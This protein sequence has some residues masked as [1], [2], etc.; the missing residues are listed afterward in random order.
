M[1]ARWLAMHPLDKANHKT[2]VKNMNNQEGRRLLPLLLLLPL[3]ITAPARAAEAQAALANGLR[4]AD[5]DLPK[6]E[7][8]DLGDGWCDWTV[9][10]ALAR[11]A[12]G[13]V[14]NRGQRAE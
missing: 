10:H 12:A 7:N 1:A 2:K 11:E 3:P 6:A 8:G 13:A 5:R 14:S 4:V 9:A